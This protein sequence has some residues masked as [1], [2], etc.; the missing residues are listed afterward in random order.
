MEHAWLTVRRSGWMPTRIGGRYGNARKYLQ[1]MLTLALGRGGELSHPAGEQAGARQAQFEQWFAQYRPLLLDYLYG[2]TRDREWAADLVQETFLHAYAASGAPEAISHPRAWLYRIA[3]NTTLSA[4]RRHR[5]FTWL[6]L[7]AVES[8]ENA[9]SSDRW[10]RPNLPDLPEY[11]FAVSV[12]ERDAV[13]KTL[14]EL[15]PR[16]RSVL[17]LQ[18]TGGFEVGE[19]AVQL[20]LSEANVRKIVFR[21]KERFR[22][23]HT[24]HEAADRERLAKGGAR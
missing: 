8:H 24:Q 10:V 22:A 20:G 23:L 9:D 17:L 14:A 2:M 3:T 12:A 4:L 7:S 13:W 5:R 19:I 21:A 11:D 18:T 6:P 15:P 16:W 1:N